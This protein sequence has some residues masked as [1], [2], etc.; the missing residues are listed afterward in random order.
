[1][2]SHPT[3]TPHSPPANDATGPMMSKT[4]KIARMVYHNSKSGAF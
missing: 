1:M 2:I 4:K 3:A